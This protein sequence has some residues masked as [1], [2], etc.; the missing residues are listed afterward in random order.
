MGLGMFINKKGAEIYFG[1]GGWNEGFSSDM[2]VHKTKGY[3]VVVLTNSNHPD[4]IDEVIRSVARAYGWANYVPVYKRVDMDTT[5]FTSIT[6]RYKNTNDGLITVYKEGAR[7]FKKTL[8]GT[9]TELF[10]ISDS[11]YITR[12]SNEVVQFKTNPSDGQFN[13][14]L[15]E[16]GKQEF[17]HPRLKAGE[18]VPYEFILTG[19]IDGAVKGYKALL[20]VNPKDESS[21]EGNLNGQGYDLLGAGKTALAI[22]V[23]KVNTVLYPNSANV[24]DSYGEA[25]AKNGDVDLAIANYKKALTLDPKLETSIRALEELKAK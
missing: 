19:D 20:S 11:S 5:A 9:P 21:S 24:Y 4:F 6:G 13:M 10:Q 22:T 25:L 7:L 18:R 14:L 16:N 15:V 12:E 17:N 1:H 2:V 23:F 3:G 8:R